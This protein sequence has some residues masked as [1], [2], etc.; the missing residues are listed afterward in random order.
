MDAS[1]SVVGTT[2][3][4]LEQVGPCTH[5]QSPTLKVARVRSA[6]WHDDRLVVIE[7]VPALVCEACGEQYYDD[8]TVVALD[9]LRGDGFPAERAVKELRVPVFSFA[10]VQLSGR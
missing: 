2:D 3:V 10:N 7:D 5:C 1:Q 6:F 9:L 4:D 8:N